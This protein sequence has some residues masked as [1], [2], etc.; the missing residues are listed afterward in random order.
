MK[1][2]VDRITSDNDATLS[3]IYVDGKWF[4]FGLEDEYREEKI[5]GET[6]IPEGVY[7]VGVRV[8]G[9]FHGRYLRR[10]GFFHQG[11]LQ[12]LDVPGFEYILIHTGNTDDHTDGCLLVGCNATTT[13]ELTVPASRLAYVPLY[14][15]VIQSALD[16]DLTIQYIDNDK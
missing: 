4:C 11:M 12:V 14:S 6:R 3:N 16:G 15:K 2:T 13:G 5:V 10:Y 1:I 9:G 8:V 7:D